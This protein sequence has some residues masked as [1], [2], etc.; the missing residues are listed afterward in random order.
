MIQNDTA[1]I[2][3]PAAMAYTA[4]SPSITTLPHR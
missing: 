3:P 4:N 2:R 1:I